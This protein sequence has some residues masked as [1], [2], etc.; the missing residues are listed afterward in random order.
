LLARATRRVQ[1]EAVRRAEAVLQD[2]VARRRQGVAVKDDVLRSDVQLSESRDALVRAREGVFDALARLNNALGRDA[3]VPLEVVDIESQPALPG[4]LMDLMEIAAGQRPEVAVA[5]QAVVV[6]QGGREAAR[7]EF[8]PRIFARAA[9]GHTDGEN[10]IT[11][12]QEGVGLHIDAPL[13]AGGRHQ[14]ELRSAEGDIASAIADAQTILDDVS[15][16]V[17]LA[18][19]AVMANEE[20]VGLARPAVEQSVEALRIV[21]QRYRAGTATPTDVIDAETAAT[22]AEQRYVSAR[23]DY[24]SALARV[25][26][27]TGA[28]SQ[29]R[30]LPP[31]GPGEAGQAPAAPRVELPPPPLSIL[32]PS[33][34]ARPAS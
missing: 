30:Y 25:A 28:E 24:L 23:I 17:N 31:A 14:G 6:A 27:V 9:A 5:Q 4:S 16:E 11:G 7:G 34:P 32:P 12:W 1:E 8:L 26:Y 2:T 19:R 20:R 18:Y 10:V 21:R 15:L 13:Y 3:G 33:I 29:S 22:R